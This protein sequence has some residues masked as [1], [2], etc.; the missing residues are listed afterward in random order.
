VAAVKA[1]SRSSSRPE[2]CVLV[3][4]ARIS[5]RS[6]GDPHAASTSRTTTTTAARICARTDRDY[7]VLDP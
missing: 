4:V 6:A 1:G 3:V 7:R 2:S 5:D